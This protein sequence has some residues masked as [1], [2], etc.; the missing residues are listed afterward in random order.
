[1]IK[2]APGPFDPGAVLSSIMS[3]GQRLRPLLLPPE[4]DLLVERPPEDLVE[5]LRVVLLPLLDLE[6]LDDFVSLF[7]PLSRE[8]LFRVLLFPESF[9]ERAD[10][11]ERVE[12]FLSAEE[13]LLRVFPESPAFVSL[14][15]LRARTRRSSFDPMFS[16]PVPR[17]VVDLVDLR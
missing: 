1:M 15:E 10:V 9:V 5:P 8:E 4:E 17:W 11:P 16:L 14:L 3:G 6:G 13:D 2:K 12:L 7:T